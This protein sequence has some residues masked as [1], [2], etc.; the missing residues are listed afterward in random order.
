MNNHPIHSSN[1]DIACSWLCSHAGQLSNQ[2]ERQLELAL[3]NLN[4]QKPKQVPFIN[5]IARVK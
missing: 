1:D 5:M 4:C 2:D 3:V